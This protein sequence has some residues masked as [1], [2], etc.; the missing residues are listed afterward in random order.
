[1]CKQPFSTMCFQFKSICS[2]LPYHSLHRSRS[3]SLASLEHNCYGVCSMRLQ[4]P[5][6]SSYNI[7]CCTC[8]LTTR[9]KTCGPVA[10]S[11]S[12]CCPTLLSVSP[13]HPSLFDGSGRT[14]LHMAPPI[15]RRFLPALLPIYDASPGPQNLEHMNHTRP[16]LLQQGRGRSRRFGGL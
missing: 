3:T 2:R 14:P 7:R 10:E 6:S 13:C 15:S 8:Y 4:S 12:W 9:Y 11:L 5:Q 1:M 16:S